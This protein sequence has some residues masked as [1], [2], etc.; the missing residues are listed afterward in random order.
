MRGASG[1]VICSK[2]PKRYNRAWINP[3]APARFGAELNAP[4]HTATPAPQ[5]P[6]SPTQDLLPDTLS[7]LVQQLQRRIR[8]EVRFDTASR[9]A[10]ACDA[11][12][13]RQVPIGVV[14]PKN[15]D[16]IPSR[17]VLR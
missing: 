11:S 14:L 10:Y 5:Q 12:N 7:T 9:A 3:S 13:Y 8:G 2:R 4:L 1:L 17:S 6:V 16:D 15:I